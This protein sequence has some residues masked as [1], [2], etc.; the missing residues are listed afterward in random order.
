MDISGRDA[1]RPASVSQ[2]RGLTG[3]G[4][5]RTLGADGVRIHR[6]LKARESQAL[7]LSRLALRYGNWAEDLS[8]NA[9]AP[10]VPRQDRRHPGARLPAKPQYLGLERISRAGAAR[11]TREPARSLA[12]WLASR[13]LRWG[14]PAPPEVPHLQSAVCRSATRGRAP[15][16]RSAWDSEV[17]SSARSRRVTTDASARKRQG[18][19]GK[20]GPRFTLFLRLSD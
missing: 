7:G 6:T 18:V 15:A 20:C 10:P 16:D 3:R 9:S 11:R 19:A 1:V 4:G 14:I 8:T 2:E 5:R 17:R 13:P 12:K